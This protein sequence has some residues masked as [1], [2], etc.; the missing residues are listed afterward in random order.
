MSALLQACREARELRDEAERQF[1]L[2]LRR[3]ASAHTLREIGRAAGMS[4]NGVRYLI[5]NPRR[6]ENK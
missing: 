2:A 1:R 5:H 4:F 3:A 6:E